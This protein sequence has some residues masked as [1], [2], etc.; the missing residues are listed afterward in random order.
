[1][2]VGFVGLGQMGAQLAN[3]LQQVARVSVWD[4][5]E[6]AIRQHV[7]K[8]GTEP[9]SSLTDL[10]HSNV[11]GLCVPSLEQSREVCKILVEKGGMQPGTIVID[12]TSGDPLET[13]AV[14]SYLKSHDICYL[15]APVSGGPAGA[16]AGTLACM[17][18]Y[19]QGDET[20][21]MCLEAIAGKLVYLDEIGAGNAVKSVNNLLNTTHLIIASQC[22]E[23]LGE[24]GVDIEKA[25]EAINGSSGRSLQ[26]EVRIPT[27][28]LSNQYNYGFK[29][30]LMHKDV[31][32]CQR[33][34]DAISQRPASERPWV[35]MTENLLAAHPS[36]D[37]ADYTRVVEQF[38]KKQNKSAEY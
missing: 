8:F 19:Q 30:G 29:L 27:E 11:I 33:F 20:I 21:D 2:R 38:Y 3:R 32:Q 17:I 24:Y 16:A 26:T 35:K 23:A 22:M 37:H 10:S 34:L 31:R 1:M 7:E 5:S 4:M 28:V 15:D 6:D 36:P 12:H 14:G 9:T 18:G 13:K 25:I